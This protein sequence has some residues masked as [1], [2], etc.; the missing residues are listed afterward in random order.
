MKIYKILAIIFLFTITSE[1]CFA[2]YMRLSAPVSQGN[3]W[4]YWVNSGYEKIII[5]D[6]VISIDSVEYTFITFIPFRGIFWGDGK[7]VRIKWNDDVV[8]RLDSTYPDINNEFIYYKKNCKIGDTWTQRNARLGGQITYKVVDTSI[9]NIFNTITTVKVINVTDG[10]IVDFEFWCEK[11][12]FLQD[13]SPFGGTEYT[14][15][16]CVIDGVLYGDT[17][18]VTDVW[19]N[20]QDF[21]LDNYNLYQNFPNPFNPATT[22]RYQIPQSGIVVLKIYDILGSE[23]ATLV[24]ETKEAGN[25]AVKFN[26]ANLPSGVY[27]YTLQVND[28]TSSKKM[29]L[30]K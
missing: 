22:I 9:A 5:K 26:P 17:S 15:K 18:T 10:L 20:V 16:G 24:N 12:G 13:A 8:V 25:F 14:L 4:V 29:L 30:M 19:E 3:I 28:F 1:Y 11:F 23:V 21:T 6:S 2:Q 27:I 7:P